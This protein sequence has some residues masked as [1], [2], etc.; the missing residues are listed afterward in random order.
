MPSVSHSR[1]PRFLFTTAASELYEDGCSQYINVDKNSYTPC[2][3]LLLS[4][5]CAVIPVCRFISCHLPGCHVT[6]PSWRHI[7]LSFVVLFIVSLVCTVVKHAFSPL[8]ADVTPVLQIPAPA[9]CLTA[10]RSQRIATPWSSRPVATGEFGGTDV[11]PSKKNVR[12][13][14]IYCRWQI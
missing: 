8:T 11:A 14:R 13:T 5:A 10:P 9:P 3:L 1:T 2:F 12:S 4:T 6:L 7:T